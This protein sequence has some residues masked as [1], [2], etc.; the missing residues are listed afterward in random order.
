[1]PSS[2]TPPAGKIWYLDPGPLRPLV[3][4][5]TGHLLNLGHT[6]LTVRGYGDTAP[7]RRVAPEFGRYDRPCRW[8]YMR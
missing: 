2:T 5:F 4:Q 1:M 8:R 6:A 7:L 3:D